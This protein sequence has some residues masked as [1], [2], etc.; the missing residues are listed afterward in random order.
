MVEGRFDPWPEALLPTPG[1]GPPLGFGRPPPAAV[2]EK[3]G[4]LGWL[5][6]GEAGT[7]TIEQDLLALG[8]STDGAAPDVDGAVRA[9]IL[10]RAIRIAHRLFRREADGSPIDGWSWGITF[11]VDPPPPDL[12]RSRAW[13]AI[14]AGDHPAA[15]G[16]VIGSGLVAVYSTFLRRT[17]YESRRLDPPLSVADRALFDGTYRWGEDKT[18]N[19]RANHVRC[20]LDGFASAVGLTLCHEF[21]HLCGCGHDTESET[22]IMNVVAGAGAAWAEA[23]WIPAHQRSVTTTLGLEGVR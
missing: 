22:S 3:H 2:N 9:E 6:W 20:L 14:V 18:L 21:G 23:T 13:T 15:G 1:C 19:F 7:R 8:L 17:M 12:P 5:T 10:G 16:E 11:S 4:R